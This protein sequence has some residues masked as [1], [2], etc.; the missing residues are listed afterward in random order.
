MAIAFAYPAWV[1]PQDPPVQVQRIAGKG[2]SYA[3]GSFALS[4]QGGDEPSAMASIHFG[5]DGPKTQ[6]L[7]S[8]PGSI[9]RRQWNL[10]AAEGNQVRAPPCEGWFCDRL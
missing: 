7:K 1:W 3:E 10:G 2:R 6:I 8:D 5:N 9:Q 4:I